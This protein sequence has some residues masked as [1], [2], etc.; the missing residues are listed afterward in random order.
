MAC[1]P[2]GGRAAARL[3]WPPDCLIGREES[4]DDAPGSRC[5]LNG[6]KW[7]TLAIQASVFLTVVALGL[8]ASFRDATALIRRPA[9]LGRAVLAMNVVMPALAL[10]LA[11]FLDLKPVV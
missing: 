10:L 5:R 9:A 4:H 3:R 11:L 2:E 1:A 8:R 6:A 7:L